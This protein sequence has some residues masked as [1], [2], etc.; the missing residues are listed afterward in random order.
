MFS[1]EKKI[2]NQESEHYGL[3]PLPSCQRYAR[4]GTHSPSSL[5]PHSAVATAAAELPATQPFIHTTESKDPTHL[6]LP[7]ALTPS[8]PTEGDGWQVSDFTKAPLSSPTKQ[9]FTLNE[10]KG[11]EETRSLVSIFYFLPSPLA[12]KEGK[13]EPVDTLALAGEPGGTTLWQVPTFSDFCGCKVVLTA[14]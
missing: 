6:T 8:C 10:N 3:C 1:L 5:S 14:S 12:T 9:C 2:P 11:P 13:V 7:G 4:L